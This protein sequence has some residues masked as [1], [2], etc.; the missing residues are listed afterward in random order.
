MG[1]KRGSSRDEPS[2]RRRKRKVDEAL[3]ADEAEVFLNALWSDPAVE[4]AEP[5]AMAAFMYRYHQK[6]MNG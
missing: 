2:R 4:Y 3:P 5:D 1:A 6:Y